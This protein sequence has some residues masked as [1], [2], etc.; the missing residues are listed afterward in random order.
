MIMCRRLKNQQKLPVEKINNM[1]FRVPGAAPGMLDNITEVPEALGYT[2]AMAACVT[3]ENDEDA[4]G[5]K[6]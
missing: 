4:T 5:A 1:T 2:S 6:F 3:E